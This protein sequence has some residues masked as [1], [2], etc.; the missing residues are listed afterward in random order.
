M[1]TR[2]WVSRLG[3][4]KEDMTAVAK[5]FPTSGRFVPQ[6]A[7]K[8][9]KPWGRSMVYLS[10]DADT[11]GRKSLILA[12][13]AS[14]GMPHLRY[15]RPALYVDQ[16][17]VAIRKTDSI[18]THMRRKTELV[19][20]ARAFLQGGSKKYGT[21]PVPLLGFGAIIVHSWWR[22]TTQARQNFESVGYLGKL[23]L[24]LPDVPVN[25]SV[26]KSEADIHR[27]T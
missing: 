18:S 15:L 4:Q 9:P 13:L 24:F 21:K 11:L 27:N 1:P 26:R 6:E 10:K 23:S 8:T 12:I 25:C 14:A 3:S 5:D 22:S 2:H 19:M 7:S 17:V 20:L 16:D